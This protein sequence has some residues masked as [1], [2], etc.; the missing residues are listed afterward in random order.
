MLSPALSAVSETMS[1]ELGLVRVP[2]NRN[3][4]NLTSELHT[5]VGALCRGRDGALLEGE[6]TQA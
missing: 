3:A 6:I 4:A 5:V 2:H 1:E